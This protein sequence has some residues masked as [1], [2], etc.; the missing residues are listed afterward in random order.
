MF[1][2]PFSTLGQHFKIALLWNCWNFYG[3]ARRGIAARRKAQ[4]W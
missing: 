1:D 3:A 2:A 4:V